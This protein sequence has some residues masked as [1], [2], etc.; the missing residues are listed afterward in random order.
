MDSLIK[1]GIVKEMIIVQPDARHRHGG[2]QYANSSVSGNWADFIVK[3][4][5]EYIDHN[6]RTLAKPESRGL[7]GS[8]MGGRGVLDI[9]LKSTEVY[10]VVYAMF[11]GQMGFRRFGLAGNPEEWHKLIMIKDPNTT[12]RSLRRIL[13]F[14]VAFS[15]NP[16]APPYFADFPMVLDGESMRINEEVMQRWSRFDPIEVASENAE[17]LLKLNALYFDCG[18]SDP[19][20]EAARLFASILTKQNIPYVYDEYE[21]GHG[22]PGAKRFKSRVLLIFSEHL[23]FK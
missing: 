7:V 13:G 22:D 1:K 20:L 3:D 12:D 23:V 8:S 2:C 16:D 21:G 15:P 5:V 6:Y 10:G 11:P 4:L 14:A 19:G 9:A 18:L 17:P